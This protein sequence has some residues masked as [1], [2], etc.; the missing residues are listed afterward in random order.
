MITTITYSLLIFA[1]LFIPWLLYKKRQHVKEL[2]R[3]IEERVK[4]WKVVPIPEN[5]QYIVVRAKELKKDDIIIYS[6]LRFKIG[7]CGC[8]K[9]AG[10][11]EFGEYFWIRGEFVNT[12]PTDMYPEKGFIIFQESP[13]IKCINGVSE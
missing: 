11:Y 2:N 12:N 5:E 9:F 13:T 10:S 1:A 6:G 3:I 4:N 7:D 8:G